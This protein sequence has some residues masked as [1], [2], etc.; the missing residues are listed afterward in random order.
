[1]FRLFKSKPAIAGGGA[2]ANWVL[3]AVNHPMVRT[4]AANSFADIWLRGVLTK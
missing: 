3:K 2:A 4:S 1:M